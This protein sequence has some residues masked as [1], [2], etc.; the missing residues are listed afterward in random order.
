MRRSA[1]QGGELQ[2]LEQGERIDVNWNT[3]KGILRRGMSLERDGFSFYTAA[4]D[5]AS[6]EPGRRMFL[7]L[8]AQEADHLRLLLVEYRSLEAGRGW[9]PYQEAL[10][11]DLDVDMAHPDLPG[12]EPPDPPAVFTRDRETSL[13][14]DI[15]ALEYGM[16]TERIS[17]DLYAQGA[18]DAALE[19]RE[20]YAF[21]VE[22]EEGH[23]RLLQS[24]HEYLTQNGT[25]WDTGEYPFFIG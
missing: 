16:E 1:R 12:E 8:A 7:D 21:L 24:T 18:Q 3:P 11:V 17:R 9:L 6:D 14:G 23:Y 15:A 2:T 25:W 5:N 13:E 10:A 19:A 4:A 22:Q 20:A